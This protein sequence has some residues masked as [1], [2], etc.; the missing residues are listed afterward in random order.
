MPEDVKLEKIIDIMIEQEIV[1]A[2]ERENLKQGTFHLEFSEFLLLPHVYIG[3]MGRVHYADEGD[4]DY[5]EFFFKFKYRNTDFELNCGLLTEEKIDGEKVENF[6]YTVD[7][8]D[9]N[10]TNTKRNV[11]KYYYYLGMVEF[12]RT[13]AF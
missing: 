9:C 6:K 1:D 11:T 10:L 5:E 4:Q 7:V 3:N 12:T 8:K 13:E 2:T